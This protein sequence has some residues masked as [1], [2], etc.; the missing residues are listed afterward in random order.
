MK[1]FLL[2]LGLLIGSSAY[3]QLPGEGASEDRRAM[4]YYQ[5]AKQHKRFGRTEMALISFQK[6]LERDPEFL[7]ALFDLSDMYL[8]LE[9]IDD[10]RTLMEKIIEIDKTYAPNVL[11]NLGL[12]AQSQEKF[13][14][15]Q[16]Y[17]EEYLE[18]AP[19]N[20]KNYRF[21][22]QGAASAEFAQWAMAN[23]VPTSTFLR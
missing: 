7:D 16:S 12:M 13:A 10:A 8:R 1:T 23:P 6:A 15:A 19:E 17:F 21:A 2:L 4:N 9:R 14:E 5:E 11:I 18:I 3:A 22:K 20:S